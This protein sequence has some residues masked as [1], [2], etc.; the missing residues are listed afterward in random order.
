M[1]VH[2]Q[3][4]AASAAERAGSFQLYEHRMTVHTGGVSAGAGSSPQTL[5]GES[6][7][8]ELAEAVQRPLG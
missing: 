4:A 8:Q 3:P 7:F 1:T 2:T 5:P 6:E